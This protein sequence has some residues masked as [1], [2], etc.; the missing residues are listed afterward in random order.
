MENVQR[1]FTKA[2]PPMFS[3][4]YSEWFALHGLQD[5]FEL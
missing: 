4:P 2:L 1:K 5:L 3:L